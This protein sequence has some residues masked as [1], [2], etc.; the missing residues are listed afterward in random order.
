M[1]HYAKAASFTALHLKLSVRLRAAEVLDEAANIS[2]I[3]SINLEPFLLRVQ[4]NKENIW[5]LTFI[6]YLFGVGQV[7]FGC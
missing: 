2:N 4:V 6:R 3:S 7:E 1:L 5:S